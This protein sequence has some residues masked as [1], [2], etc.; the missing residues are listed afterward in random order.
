MGRKLAILQS[1]FPY[2]ICASTINKDWFNLNMDIVWQVF[3]E[4]LYMVS[5]VHNLKIHSFV[6]MSNHFHLIASTPKANISQCMHMFM[7]QVS[8]RLT[9]LKNRTSGTFGGRHYKTVLNSCSYIEN[10]YKYNYRN[11]VEAGIC[12]RVED[13]KYSS[14]RGVL[15]LEKLEFPVEESTDLIA[16]TE[17]QLAWLNEKPPKEKVEAVRYALKRP[18]FQSKK[19]KM[20]NKLILGINEVI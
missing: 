12:K 7:G 19:N 1:V 6:L 20:T 8:R 5:L 16:S 14:L 13:Y 4:E 17:D 2:N 10:A 18:Y 11:P 3:C 15:G 9:A